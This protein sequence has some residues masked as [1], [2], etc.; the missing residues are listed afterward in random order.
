MLSSLSRGSLNG[1]TFSIDFNSFL[2]FL[3]QILIIT[4]II[5]HLNARLEF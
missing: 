4:D 2:G 5:R 1:M 3:K